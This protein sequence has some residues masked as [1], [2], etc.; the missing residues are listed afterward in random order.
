MPWNQNVGRIMRYIIWDKKTKTY[1]G[2][3]S[4]ASDF[5]SLSPRDNHIKWTF[6]QRT[7]EKMLNYTGMG[8]T[9]APTQPLGFSYLGGKLAAL[10]LCSDRAVNAWNN[11]YKEKLISITT[12]SLYGGFSQYNNLKYW[13]KC[14]T[15]EG[16]IPLEPTDDVYFKIRDWVKEKYPNDFKKMTCNDEKILSRPKSKMLSFA[17]TKL[18]IKPPENNAPRGVYYCKLYEKSNEFLS[19]RTTK[20][21]KKAFDNRLEVLVDLWKKKYAEKRVNSIV[22]DGRYSKE[23]LY[24]DDLI[25]MEWGKAREKYLKQ[26][27]R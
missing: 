16:K 3:L 25:G 21:G 15:T 17:Y 6:E 26:V 18:D 4:M 1:L 9:I 24:Y 23:F 27:G 7:K 22:N 13:K 20:L 19:N 5:I 11:R 2:V 10:C 8:S 12:T 14:G